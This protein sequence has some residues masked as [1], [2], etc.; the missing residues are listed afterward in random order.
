[1]KNLKLAFTLF[2]IIN[3]VS[4][5][6]K[7]LGV[8]PI[9]DGKVTY[10]EVV[11]VKGSSK[12]ELNQRAKSWFAKTFKSSQDV[13]QMDEISQLIGKGF[14]TIRAGGSGLG[15][16]DM[17]I[18]ITITLQFKDGRYRFT[19]TDF[20]GKTQGQYADELPLEDWN[21]KWK[22]QKSRDKRNSKVYPEVNTGIQNI[23]GSLKDEMNSNLNDDW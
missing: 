10:T 14:Y 6:D 7:L 17:E 9:K 2:L 21:N 3:F 23:I 15:G 5:Q 13:I 1:M 19:I 12:E 20:I 18:W 11:E 16:Y 4:A 22:N 8:L